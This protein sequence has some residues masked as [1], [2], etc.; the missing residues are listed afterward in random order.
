MSN[1]IELLA[2]PFC[3]GSAILQEHPAHTHAVATFMPDHAGSATVECT[4]CNVGM[5]NDTVALVT[6]D[7]NTRAT[8]AAP[9]TCQCKFCAQVLHASDCAVH[10]MPGYPNGY[11]DC[12]ALAAPLQA[13]GQFPDIQPETRTSAEYKLVVAP[14]QSIVNGD[15]AFDDDAVDQFSSA[16]KL[17]LDKK[18]LQGRNGW[19]DRSICSQ[20]QLSNMLLNHVD[21]GDP[22]DVGNFAMMLFMRQEKIVLPPPAAPT[23]T[24][25]VILAL[26]KQHEIHGYETHRAEF[27]DA[28][29]SK[30]GAEA[31]ALSDDL[32]QLLKDAKE[33]ITFCGVDPVFLSV[34]AR[35]DANLPKEPT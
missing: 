14:R 32:I 1:D 6:A 10:N 34:I 23:L 22:V 5:I 18:R 29:I 25:D 16:M 19:H 8:L 26:M 2:C 4:G 15:K 9:S 3:G 21:K 30:L 7:W 24:V 17:K 12:G 11:C 31:P 20:K 28:I 13:G 33:C 27:A 35:I